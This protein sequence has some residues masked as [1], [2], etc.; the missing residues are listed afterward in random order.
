[1]LF[2][3]GVLRQYEESGVA[4]M[5]LAEFEARLAAI[6]CEWGEE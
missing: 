2:G 5:T 4:P 1:M 6:P 3:L